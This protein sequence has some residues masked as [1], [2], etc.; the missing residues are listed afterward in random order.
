MDYRFTI[1]SAKDH[2]ALNGTV[3]LYSG[4][5]KAGLPVAIPPQGATISIPD[6]VT[7]V[8]VSSAG[9]YDHYSAVSDL[10]DVTEFRLDKKPDTLLLIGVGA[11]I[12]LLGVYYFNTQSKKK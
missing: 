7:Q 2:S 8:Q 12:A 4:Q 10:Y 6:N 5:L 11:G 3:Q 9:Y 1:V